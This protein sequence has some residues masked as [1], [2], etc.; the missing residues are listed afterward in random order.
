[1]TGRGAP[2]SGNGASASRRRWFRRGAARRQPGPLEGLERDSASSRRRLIA[3]ALVAVLLLAGI[4][5]ALALR[6]YEDGKRRAILDL[7]ARAASVGAV[8]DTSFEGQIA[9]LGAI[10]KAPPVVQGDVPA[11]NVYFS[12][13]DPRRIGLFNGGIGWIDRRGFVRAS[14][15]PRQRTP[16]RLSDRTYFQ[17]AVGTRSPYVS[18]GIVGRTNN[19]PII[20][21]AVPTFG[22]SG[23]VSGVLAGTILLESLARGTQTPELGFVGLQVIDRNGQLLLQGLAPV[24]NTS[25]VARIRREGSGVIQ[26]T[27]GLDGRGDD[28]VAFATSRVPGWVT[29]IDR[30]RS[31]VFSDARRALALEFAS[32]IGA[33][34]LVIAILVFVARRARR[35]SASQRERARSWTGLTRA[36][37]S[38]ST[39]PEVAGALLTS[40]AAA[41]PNAVAVVGIDNRGRLLVDVDSRMP[42]ARRI[43][44]TAPALEA[45]ATRGGDG[46][47]TVPLDRE[48]ELRDVHTGSGRRLKALHT[49]PIPA[50]EGQA[51]GTISL[52]STSPRLE[53]AEW[54]LLLS[55]S[56]QA[57]QA[58]QRAVLFAHEHDLAVRLQ[59]SLLPERLPSRDG[60]ELAGHYRAGEE[61][62]EVGGDWYDAVR[63][64][65]GVVHLC[66]GDVSGKGVGAAVVMS[67]QR[68]T[69]QVYG[70]E[71]D[72][73]A[74][75]VRHMLQHGDTDSMITLAVVSIDPYTGRLTYSC[76]GHPPPLLL[77]RATGRVTR[78]DRASAPPIGVAGPADVVEAGLPL[79]DEAVLVLYT[80]GL[81]E[82]RG[83]DIDR[84]IDLLGTLVAEEPDAPPDVLLAKIGATIGTTDDDVALLVASVNAE[85]LAFEVEI[86][87][88]PVM[89]RALRRRLE[90]WLMQR[91]IDR[92]DVVDVVLAV[93]EACNNSIEHAYSE[94]GGGPIN[95]S[96]GKDAEA[97]RV[98]VE[99]HGTWRD[100]TPSEERGR[101]LM[102]IRHLM[103][104]SN[105]ETGLH[106]TRVSFVRRVRVE[107][108][109]TAELASAPLGTA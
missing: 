62:I 85:R 28:V 81:I 52:V 25:L 103:H 31:S 80:D 87:A 5:T 58:L 84:A 101:G 100:P 69:F 26:S 44:E 63:R 102:L 82:R 3:A 41:F 67:R 68:H 33:L 17:R 51:G 73:P 64:P 109:A 27:T 60:L 1:M 29:V 99:D 90:A 61:A 106:G 108:T 13:L 37:A 76:V 10:A 11:M 45:I 15:R 96:I 88:E 21:V 16:G 97:L 95:V 75:I 7:R 79:P 57:T 54:A 30:P 43:V 50:K 53:P 40:L 91:G 77:D 35:D 104:A 20:V 71:L 70:R 9:T 72:S 74:Q 14:D 24:Q 83:Q 38:A 98:T 105:V 32:V 22:R 56:D 23:A 47:T 55:F 36:L 2:L 46:P 86:Q 66:V 4:A 65:D 12:R 89:L 8:I 78:L 49:L 18:A 34:L 93:S 19:Q 59:R 39:P 92:D 6:Q 94:N 48:P 42:R 107:R